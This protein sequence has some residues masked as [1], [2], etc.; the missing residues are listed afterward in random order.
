MKEKDIEK[1]ESN[2]RFF[3]PSD[4]SSILTKTIDK[5]GVY[6]WNK[7]KKKEIKKDFWY[8]SNDFFKNSHLIF[9]KMIP[10]ALGKDANENKDKYLK[11]VIDE[12]NSLVKT[13]FLD[14]IHARF[15]YVIETMKNNGNAIKEFQLS[16]LWRMVIGLGASHPQET[17]M[18]FHHIY[19]IPYIPASAIKG[20]TR[21][22]VTAKYF[23][24]N[25]DEALKDDDF[26]NIFGTQNKK[27]KI[28]FFDAY[29]VANINLKIDV[30]T[31]HYPDYYSDKKEPADWQSPNPIKF[32]TVERTTFNFYLSCKENNKLLDKALPWLKEALS[33]FGIGAKTAIGYGYFKE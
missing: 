11:L 9:G 33:K 3:N 22:W 14:E 12:I 21:H 13:E 1:K 29:P 18:T 31:P 25:E 4:T 2:Y 32:L 23:N 28:I 30:M 16:L 24:N 20:I 26:M 6:E 8:K 10:S 5:I 27:G 17:S 15:K 7:K 19:G